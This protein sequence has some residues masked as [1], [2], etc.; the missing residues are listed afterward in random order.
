M[1]YII[2]LSSIPLF[3]FTLSQH[4][5]GSS[6]PVSDCSTVP[7]GCSMPSAPS[8]RSERIFQF[9]LTGFSRSIC[10]EHPPQCLTLGF[11][12]ISSSLGVQD[13]LISDLI[14]HH[15]PYSVHI[16]RFRHI[17]LDMHVVTKTLSGLRG[18][19]QAI[20][21]SPRPLPQQAETVLNHLI[22]SL[23]KKKDMY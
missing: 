14:L 16:F 18:N 21:D 1:E 9:V 6:R 13:V 4:R 20:E 8:S 3:G 15:A 17:D 12:Y 23:P 19:S 2:R 11:P 5:M 10:K 7:R 22:G